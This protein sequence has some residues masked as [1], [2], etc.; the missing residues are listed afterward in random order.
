MTT[1]L[2]VKVDSKVKKILKPPKNNHVILLNN[3]VTP[4]DFVI[5]Y[6]EKILKH[7]QETAKDLTPKV[8]KNEPPKVGQ[9]T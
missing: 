6:W 1:E 3:E 8:K 7:K 5:E 2:D 9:K 4:M